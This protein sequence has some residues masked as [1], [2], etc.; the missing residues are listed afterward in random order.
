MGQPHPPTTSADQLSEHRSY[1]GHPEKQH[2]LAALDALQA[3]R[4]SPEELEK[5][6]QGLAGVLERRGFDRQEFERIAR[7]EVPGLCLEGDHS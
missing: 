3:S 2:F 7:K 4:S 6:L 1:L 5:L